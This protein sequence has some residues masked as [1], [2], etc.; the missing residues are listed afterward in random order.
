MDRPISENQQHRITRDHQ[1]DDAA[2]K[3]SRLTQVNGLD[4]E[5]E[6]VEDKENR[7]NKI[8]ELLEGEDYA[9]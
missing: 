5:L 7:W 6:F 1:L 4:V 2:A 9:Q 8:F 3:T